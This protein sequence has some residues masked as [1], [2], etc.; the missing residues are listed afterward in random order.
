MSQVLV[1]LITN[2]IH[3]LPGGGNITVT[4]KQKGTHVSLAVQDNGTG[5]TAEIKQKIFEPFFTTK[6]VG[7]GTGLGLSVVLGIIES[8]QGS[9]KVTTSPGKGSKFEILLPVKQHLK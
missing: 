1:N 4:T 2:A 8:H 5:M 3:A 6:P 9:I 7:Q